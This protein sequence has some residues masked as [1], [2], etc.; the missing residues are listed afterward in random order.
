M[1]NLDRLHWITQC[2]P[3]STHGADFFV[4]LIFARGPVGRCPIAPARGAGSARLSPLFPCQHCMAYFIQEKRE[5]ERDAAWRVWTLTLFENYNNI[6][7]EAKHCPSNHVIFLIS[8]LG[9]LG[10][11][12][13]PIYNRQLQKNPASKRS[14]SKWLWGIRQCCNY[15][16]KAA[17][18]KKSGEVE[19]M[20]VI[21]TA[22]QEY[23]ER[24][25]EERGERF[26]ITSH[27]STSSTY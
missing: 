6:N 15:G 14:G 1:A 9:N 5:R 24:V 17:H 3:P 18:L 26:W 13:T 2:A 22:F 21:V 11:S 8:C 4:L 10:V 20:G 12:T 16:R 25:R 27:R 19:N 7:S 23:G